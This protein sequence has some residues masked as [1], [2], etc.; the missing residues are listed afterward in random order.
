[1]SAY[2]MDSRDLSVLA[3]A[4]AQFGLNP[5]D[6]PA[7]QV[8]DLLL[9]E[10][11]RSVGYRYPDAQRI[12]DWDDRGEA[13]YIYDATATAR[14]A[15]EVLDLAKSC[16]YQS[17]EHPEYDTSF[18]KRYLSALE[19]AF[20]PLA[21]KEA[22]AKAAEQAARVR[23]HAAL[24]SLGPKE[25]AA[26]IRGILKK[27]FP[28]CKFSVVTE[29]G[30]MVSSVRISWTDG[31]TAARVD[32]IVKT[33]E[34]GHFDG[35]TDSYDYDPSRYLLIDGTQY[36]PGCQYVFTSRQISDTLANRCIAQLVAY[37]GG[38]DEIPTATPGYFGHTLP[39]GFSWKPVRPDL[40][41]AHYSWQSAI[42]Q[43]AEDRTRFARS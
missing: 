21:Q 42:R 4:P 25:T 23:A 9:D 35:M 32:S 8:Y 16:D 30:S 19:M 5:A 10:N 3:N 6:V 11:L 2:L 20:A 13:A 1:M 31:P 17:C 26:V 38:V 12:T 40:D 43:A 22:D 39:E 15:S 7:E 34:A 24:P 41:H 28:A 37:W 14:D 29:R 36:R 27:T 18:A 33:F